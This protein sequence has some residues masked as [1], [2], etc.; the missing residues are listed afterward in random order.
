[1]GA[2]ENIGM[3]LYDVPKGSK[4]RVLGR[5][6]VPPAAPEI[7][8][9][10]ELTLNNLDGMYSNCTN[11]KGETVHLSATAQVEIIH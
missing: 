7:K 9:E 1:M 10:E 5:N 2:I 11:S 6:A 8:V 3:P 4:F